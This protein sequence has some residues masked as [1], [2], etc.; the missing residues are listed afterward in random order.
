MMLLNIVKQDCFPVNLKKISLRTRLQKYLCKVYTPL[1]DLGPS[2]THRDLDQ[3]I[4]FKDFLFTCINKWESLVTSFWSKPFSWSLQRTSNRVWVAV[5][6]KSS[7]M[8]KL[9]FYILVTQVIFITITSIPWINWPVPHLIGCG[10]EA[11]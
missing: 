3:R 7:G 9:H 6:Q 5:N 10:E 4:H 2:L 11:V 1:P 8:Y